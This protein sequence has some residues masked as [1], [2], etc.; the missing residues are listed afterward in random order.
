MQFEG[1]ALR[2]AAVT[3]SNDT[4]IGP[5]LGLYV[6]VGGDVTVE[7]MTN[8][9]PVTFTDVATGSFLPVSVKKVNATG[10]DASS[11][12]ALFDS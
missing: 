12:V 5:T 4:Q 1:I 7:F 10:T 2:G 11:I 6:G 8:D 3:P 9:T